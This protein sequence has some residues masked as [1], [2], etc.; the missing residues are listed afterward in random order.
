MLAEL[1]E[2]GWPNPA[3]AVPHPTLG[4][5]S[6]P[7]HLFAPE[8]G[9]SVSGGR[10]AAPPG[11]DWAPIFRLEPGAA[12]ETFG[13]ARAAWRDG[14]LE[15]HKPNGEAGLFFGLV[16][17]ASHRLKVQ[18]TVLKPGPGVASLWSRTAV[19]W[20]LTSHGA[21]YRKIS[22]GV[23]R[24]DLEVGRSA[25][26]RGVCIC[27]SDGPDPL[28]IEDLVVYAPIGG[29]TVAP[30]AI[31]DFGLESEV[32]PYLFGSWWGPLPQ[33]RWTYGSE[34]RL[35]FALAGGG[36]RLW[37]LCR[38]AG[39]KSPAGVRFD[40]LGPGGEALDAWVFPN[41]GWRLKATDLTAAAGADGF[42]DITFVSDDLER[43]IDLG[44]SRDTRLV[45]LGVRAGAVLPADADPSEVEAQFRRLVG[46]LPFETAPLRLS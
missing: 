21:G 2:G 1:C 44:V 10:M 11:P 20:T 26:L 34:G 5:Y 19:D 30:G 27:P 25:S 15:I 13:D 43:P 46:K 38:V 8:D 9:S 28:W 3:P 7:S 14:R 35:R 12:V 16:D 24:L 31:I 33:I 40:I 6:L 4:R 36:L 39:T 42:A 17:N 41:E 32:A 18:A 45:G 29:P 37:L 23:D 22:P